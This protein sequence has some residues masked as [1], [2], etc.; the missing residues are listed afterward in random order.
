MLTEHSRQDMGLQLGMSVIAMIKASSVTLAL[1]EDYQVS[2]RNVLVGSL[3][4]LE[5]GAVNT[6]VTID[7]SG[8][9]S[10]SAVITNKSAMQMGLKLGIKTSAMFKASSV[11]V[12]RT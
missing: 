8:N 9:K 1:G 6:D 4:A 11:I 7:L 3:A 2:A 5:T 12:M 10:L